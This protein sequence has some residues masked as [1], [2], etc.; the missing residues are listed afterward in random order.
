MLGNTNFYT[1]N[2]TKCAQI[3]TNNPFVSLKSLHNKQLLS[4]QTH[5]RTWW[6]KTTNNLVL[7]HRE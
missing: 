4:L 6:S 7:L 5:D 1:L 2:Q 3:R